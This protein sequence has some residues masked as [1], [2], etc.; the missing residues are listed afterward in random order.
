MCTNVLEF[1]HTYTFIFSG[2]AIIKNC[3]EVSIR[4]VQ[5]EV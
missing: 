3:I 4:Y 2:Q 1:N 5:I